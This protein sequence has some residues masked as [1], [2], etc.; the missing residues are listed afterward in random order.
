MAE[1]RGISSRDPIGKLLKLRAPQPICLEIFSFSG[2]A[3]AKFP[4]LQAI[5]SLPWHVSPLKIASTR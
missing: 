4:K 3:R 1:T 5:R 2:Y